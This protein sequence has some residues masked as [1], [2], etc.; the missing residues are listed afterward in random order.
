MDRGRRRQDAV[1]TAE[2]APLAAHRG[3]AMFS[4]LPLALSSPDAVGLGAALLLLAYLVYA[5]VRAERF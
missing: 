1:K 3:E 5:L 4:A 2:T